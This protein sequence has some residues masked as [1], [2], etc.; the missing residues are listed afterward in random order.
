MA[1]ELNFHEK[2]F[3]WGQLAEFGKMMDEGEHL[4]DGGEWIKEEYDKIRETLNSK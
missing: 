4:K 3:L 1:R 2:E